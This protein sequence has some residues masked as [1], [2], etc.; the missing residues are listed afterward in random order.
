V[1]LCDAL[2]VLNVPEYTVGVDPTRLQYL[3]AQ[4]QEAPRLMVVLA[5]TELQI[6]APEEQPR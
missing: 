2:N 6:S 5:V 1:K 4:L 3:P